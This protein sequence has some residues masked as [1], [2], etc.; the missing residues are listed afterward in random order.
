MKGGKP[1]RTISFRPYVV[2]IIVVALVFIATD[3][4]LIGS[5]RSYF[6]K[7]LETESL[8]YARVYSHTLTKSTDAYNIINETLERRLLSASR[9]AALQARNIDDESLMELAEVLAVDDI[10]VYNAEGVIEY[11]TREEYLGWRAYPGHPVY[12]F[13][14]SDAY[15]LVEGIRPDSES[16]EFYKYGYFRVNGGRF[17]QLGVK[18]DLIEGFLGAFE[19]QHLFEEIASLELVDHVFF[20]N[21]DYTVE[22]SF[23]PA[24]IGYIVTD[25]EIQAVIASRETHTRLNPDF[26][27]HGEVYQVYLPIY[28]DSGYVGTL[29]VGKSTE[30]TKAL[31]KTATVSSS[32]LAAVVF[33]GFVYVMVSHFRHNK[34]LTKV[35]F[36]DSLTGLPNKAYLTELLDEELT[37]TTLGN[38]AILMIHV[39]NLSAINSTYG[40]AVGDMALVELTQKLLKLLGE[41]QQ[42]FRF[43]ASRLILYV[44][45][46]RDSAD[47]AALAERMQVSVSQS[48]DFVL[49]QL[50]MKTGIVELNSGHRSSVDVLTQAAVAL[51]YIER[52]AKNYAFYDAQ[53][54]AHLHRQEIIAQELSSFL[55]NPTDDV[56]Y[57]VYQPKVCLASNNVVGFEALSRMKSPSFGPVS[58]L[59]FIDIAEHQDLI[60]P[61][62]QWVLSTACRFIRRLE[63]EGFSSI[64][65]AV[66]VSVNELAQADFVHS[67]TTVVRDSGINPADL[68]LEITESGLI[69]DF[70]DVTEKLAPLRALGITIALDDFGTGYSALSRIEELPIDCIKIDKRFIDN[71]MVRDRQRLI[72]QELISM[73]HKLGL[74]VVAEGVEHDTQRQYLAESGCN[75]MQ[76]FLYSKPL[77]EE[78]AIER[79]RQSR[80]G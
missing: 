54:E 37:S 2:V 56:L 26:A 52:G 68:Q 27:G 64:H 32:V 10:F 36:L 35:A 16:G 3:M 44:Q 73:C 59:E 46:Y 18:A 74:Q 17:V 69:E 66:N 80:A 33:A 6:L 77:E 25:P 45:D 57:L 65:V 72:I 76:G 75:T 60:V 48:V 39:K 11:S 49:K 63:A 58:P 61:L 23:D 15:S 30:A 12:E 13:M 79:L 21:S 47:L 7:M 78:A 9:T 41:K 19:L 22:A 20:L 5:I 71:I 42:L 4:L 67:V 70:G 1:K 34:E 8:N 55:D 51:Q 31:M 62:G 40:F 43:G 38:R 53:M 50:V 24:H 14:V 28:L 29:V